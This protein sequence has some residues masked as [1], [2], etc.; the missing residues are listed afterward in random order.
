MKICSQ[1]KQKLEDSESF[2]ERRFR[3]PFIVE[4]VLEKHGKSGVMFIDKNF[5]QDFAEDYATYIRN[6]QLVLKENEDLRGEDYDDKDIVE[7]EKILELG[8]EVGYN[9]KIKI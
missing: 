4:M 5:L 6:W 9:E 8:F 7:Q 2:R 1:I 3:A